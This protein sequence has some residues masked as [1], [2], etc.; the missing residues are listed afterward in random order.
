MLEAI[1]NDKKS[2]IRKGQVSQD[3]R[4]MEADTR[5][6]TCSKIASPEKKTSCRIQ[7]IIRDK[8]FLK[9]VLKPC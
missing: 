5:Q 6:A 2:K 4:K 7:V 8:L 9:K 1:E 3:G